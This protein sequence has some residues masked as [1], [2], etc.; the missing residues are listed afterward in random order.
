MSSLSH[1]SFEIEAIRYLL[2]FCFHLIWCFF[3][4]LREFTLY[5]VFKVHWWAQV[6]SNHRPHAY[7]A[8]ALTNWAMSPYLV[9]MNGFEPM[10]SC[11]QGRRSPNWATPPYSVVTSCQGLPFSSLKMFSHLQNHIVLL[12]F[13]NAFFFSATFSFFRFTP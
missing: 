13:P 9:E 3:L 4:F 8:C 7:Q 6:D 12:T 5:A 10:A 11:L 2:P 1:Q